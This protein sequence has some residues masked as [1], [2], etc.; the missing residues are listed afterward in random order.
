MRV[1]PDHVH[2]SGVGW[3]ESGLSYKS[4]GST[5][6]IHEHHS[7]KR[8]CLGRDLNLVRKFEQSP[9]GRVGVDGKIILK[10]ILNIL[11]VSGLD[12]TG[13]V[14]WWIFGLHKRREISWLA[15]RLSAS[16]E[17]LCSMELAAFEIQD[18]CVATSSLCYGNWLL[19]R[20]E[21]QKTIELSL[22]WPKS[23]Q[24]LRYYAGWSGLSRLVCMKHWWK[25]CLIATGAHGLPGIESVS[26]R[27]GAGRHAWTP[28]LPLLSTGSGRAWLCFKLCKEL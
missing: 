28:Q 17:G 12:S 18:S 15:E 19:S 24:R 11:W 25:S 16:H 23:G 9:F 10:W 2:W 4:P 27:R 26:M 13:S 22:S 5:E 3:G 7:Q 8:R 6:E 20:L 14:I 1:W 21:M